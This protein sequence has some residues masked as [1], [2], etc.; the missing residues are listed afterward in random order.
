MRFQANESVDT[1]S[2]GAL[3]PQPP[4]KVPQVQITPLYSGGIKTY[5]DAV[6]DQSKYQ[7][8][9]ALQGTMS[10]LDNSSTAMPTSLTMDGPGVLCPGRTQALPNDGWTVWQS[11]DKPDAVGDLEL[12]TALQSPPC[13]Q[14]APV[15]IQCR[16]IA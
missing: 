13:G 14:N 8:F 15:D 11:N 10:P 4:T 12:L 6:G 5:I 2:N 1:V 3:T 9:V 16:R 7:V